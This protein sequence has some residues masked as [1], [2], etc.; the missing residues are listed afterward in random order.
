MKIE[1]VRE[2]I[3]VETREHLITLVL[4][5]ETRSGPCYELHLEPNGAAQLVQ[6]LLAALE[7]V[8]PEHYDTPVPPVTFVTVDLSAVH[9][10]PPSFSS[11]D[12]TDEEATLPGNPDEDDDA[13]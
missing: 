7:K 12:F 8:L 11:F 9:A 5:D 3:E 6:D 10:K 13:S 4:G 2:T 1:A